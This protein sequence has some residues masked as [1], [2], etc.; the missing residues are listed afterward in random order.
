MHIQPFQAVYPDMG[1]I[2]SPDHFFST[3]KE[4]FND[5][6]ESGFYHRLPHEGMYIHRISGAGRTF[7]GLIACMDVNDYMRGEVKKHENTLA[8]SEQKQIHLL[9]KRS[10]QVKPIMLTYPNVAEIDKI[11]AAYIKNNDHFL[12]ATFEGTGELHRFWE[13]CDGATVQRLQKIFSEKVPATYIADGHHRTSSTVTMYERHGAENAGNV[14]RWLPCALYPTSEVEI[15][16]FNRIIQGLNNFSP[17]S[18]MAK[19]SKLFEIDVL[20]EMQ[21]PAKKHELTL[22]LEQEWY[23]LAWRPEILEEYKK[24]PVVLDVSLLNEKVM[25]DILHIKDVRTDAR[26][27]YHQGTKPLSDLRNKT[28]KGEGRFAFCLFPV[29]LKDFL[30]ISDAGGTLPPKS[31][32]FEP[33]IRSGLLVRRFQI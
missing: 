17:A 24:Q 19:L 25:G 27:K 20:E 10:S 31:T 9:L 4:K 7:I 1:L 26:V 15:F 33:R 6:W 5:Y 14:F 18:F 21:K 30:A 8:A 23:R 13:I 22:F 2:T 29:T 32:W 12:E 3:V 28:L 16:D 11:L